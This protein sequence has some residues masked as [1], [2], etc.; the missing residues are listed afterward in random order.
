MSAE[1]QHGF[2][3]G[4]IF[5]SILYG[6]SAALVQDHL[7]SEVD[8]EHSHRVRAGSIW[9]DYAHT[10]PAQAVEDTVPQK[11]GCLLSRVQHTASSVR[12]DWVSDQLSLR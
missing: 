9:D 11:E 6:E 1:F 10:L 4:N 8:G 5:S 3:I 7:S 12:H 2:Y